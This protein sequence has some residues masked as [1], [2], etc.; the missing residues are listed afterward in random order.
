MKDYENLNVALSNRNDSKDL[1]PLLIIYSKSNIKFTEN[2]THENID[3]YS[4]KQPSD[5]FL[6]MVVFGVA[7]LDISKINTE[8]T[9]ILYAR[10]KDE[11]I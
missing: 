1:T 10:L 11:K 5:T 2:I 9:E 7:K 8:K 3:I 6:S 4:I